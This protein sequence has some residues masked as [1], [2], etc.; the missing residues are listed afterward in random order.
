MPHSHKHG[1]VLVLATSFITQNGKTLLC[2]SDLFLSDTQDMHYLK[3][4]DAQKKT[5]VGILKM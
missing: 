1:H 2:S 3:I 4:P 5:L